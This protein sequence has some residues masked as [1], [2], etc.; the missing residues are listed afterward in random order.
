[1]NKH[2]LKRIVFNVFCVVFL[3]HVTQS[4]INATNKNAVYIS[5]EVIKCDTKIDYINIA[6][7][8]SNELNDVGYPISNKEESRY[9]C[10]NNGK[11]KS[12]EIYFY[13]KNENYKWFR[14]D[15]DLSYVESDSLKKLSEKEK[16]EKMKSKDLEYNTPSDVLPVN[17][18]RGKI[19][20][21]WGGINKEGLYYLYINES[22]EFVSKYFEGPF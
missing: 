5:N 6:V 20:K 9:C 7:L 21:L 22:N 2:L 10:I 18:E 8:K 11:N 1:M 14:C 16:I 4:C 12:N 3:S 15:L 17:F 19:Y 13:K